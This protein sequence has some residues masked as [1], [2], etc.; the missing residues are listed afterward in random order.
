MKTIGLIG[1]MSWE[2]TV[3]YY[4]Y[5][6]EGVKGALGGLNSA[7]I[8][9]Y[10]YNFSEVEIMQHLED[11]DE[12]TKDIIDKAVKLQ[13]AGADMIAI[14][15][16]TMHK[17]APDI[18]KIINIPLIHIADATGRAIK[19]KGQ[20]KVAL[21]GT[22]FTMNGDFYKE[23]I[24]EKFDIEVIVPN[25]KDKQIVHNIIYKELCH[26]IIKDESK[27]KY[28]EIIEKLAKEGAEGV[29]LGCTEIPLL[30]KEGDTSIPVYDTT[31]IHSDVLIKEAIK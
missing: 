4:K 31:K 17:M 20:K 26:G 13:E 5:L 9:L 21:L 11:W 6:N 7:K 23:R 29:I 16:N 10:S 28:I 25:E 18:E 2:S 30:I 19:Q 3:D 22:N 1:G 8:L 15:T 12:L 24:K 14:C 27:Y